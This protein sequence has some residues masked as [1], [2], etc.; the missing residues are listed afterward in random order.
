MIPHKCFSQKNE[1]ISDI[2]WQ[3]VTYFHFLETYAYTQY[4][5]VRVYIYIYIHTHINN[6]YM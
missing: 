2:K 1:D 4:V 6:V 5:C 3:Y